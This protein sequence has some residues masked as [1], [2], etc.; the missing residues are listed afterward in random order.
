[1]VPEEV[2]EEVRTL[3]T[4]EQRSL[5]PPSGGSGRDDDDDRYDEPSHSV[6]LTARG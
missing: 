6:R 2:L 5:Q 1:M 3:A 4:V